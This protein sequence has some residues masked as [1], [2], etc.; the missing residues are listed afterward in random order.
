MQGIGNGFGH[1]TFGGVAP[2]SGSDLE[3]CRDQDRGQQ[4]VA[5]VFPSVGLEAAHA[6]S[7]F[8]TY[9]VYGFE[10]DGHSGTKGSQ[11]VT[12]RISGELSVSAAQPTSTAFSLS[13][14][15]RT[16]ATIDWTPAYQESSGPLYSPDISS[17][18][19]EII[20]LDGW[21]SGNSL[22]ILIEYVSGDGGRWVNSFV[23]DSVYATRASAAGGTGVLPALE[24]YAPATPTA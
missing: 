23:T 6:A 21:T 17:I 12:L 15:V 16:N 3:L 8:G 13:S 22:A 2:A 9:L 18:V 7:L 1:G 19:A 24:V 10:S 14:R 4:T 11:D 20:S 5:T